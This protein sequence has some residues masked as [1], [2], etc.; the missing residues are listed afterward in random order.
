ML[1]NIFRTI[2]KIIDKNLEKRNRIFQLKKLNKCLDNF[3]K[4][5]H[6]LI[7]KIFDIEI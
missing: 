3:Q 4:D 7:Q 2:Q 5:Y 6:M 1:C